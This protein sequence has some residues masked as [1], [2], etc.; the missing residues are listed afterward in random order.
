MTRILS[1][2]QNNGLTIMILNLAPVRSYHLDTLSSLNFAN[3]TK[4]IEIREVENEPIF[5]GPSKL[6]TSSI[7]ITGNSMKRQPLRPIPA[8]ANIGLSVVGIKEKPFKSFSVFAEKP[9]SELHKGEVRKRSSDDPNSFSSRPKKLLR[10]SV[11]SSLDRAQEP[12]LSRASI[13][14]LVN[15]MVEEKLATRALNGFEK[16]AAPPLSEE[17]K[18]RLEALEH[19]VERKE[20][21]RAEGLQYLLM[22]KQHQV[23]NEDSSAL[24]MYQLALS[25]FPHNEKLAHRMLSLQEK[26]RVKSETKTSAGRTSPCPETTVAPVKETHFIEETKH[27]HLSELDHKLAPNS[28]VDRDYESDAS[29]RY[30]PRAR[31]ATKAG[32]VKGFE[33]SSTTSRPYSCSPQQL[34]PRTHHLLRIINTRDLAQIRSLKG[35]GAKKAETIVSCLCLLDEHEDG[36]LIRDL[37][38]LGGLKGVGAKT[39]ENMRNGISV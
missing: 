28:A 31:K 32:N 35:V 9:R 27:E 7:S 37:E 11:F 16:A 20:D 21:S 22:A 33:E 17:V 25:Y 13:E 36:A 23:R 4:K 8:S 3:R 29:F 24:K 2:G 39:V 26:I 34:T 12:E 30:K 19:R 6:T 1:L 18:R 14:E 10:P 15:R 5:K 38:Q